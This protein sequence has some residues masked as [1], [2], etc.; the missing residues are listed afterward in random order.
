FFTTKSNGTGLGLSISH[1]I[2]RDHGGTLDVQSHP[3]KGT[4]FVITFP[5]V[6]VGSRA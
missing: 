5:G 6:A 2:V 3:G 4:T 1:G